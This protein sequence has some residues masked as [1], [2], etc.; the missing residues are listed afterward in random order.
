[1]IPWSQF[2]N[3]GQRTMRMRREFGKAASTRSS[4]DKATKLTSVRSYYKL[5][6][7]DVYRSRP[8]GTVQVEA[9]GNH[10]PCSFLSRHI[11]SPVVQPCC[12]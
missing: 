3:A 1:M 11:S 5:L 2:V 12:M 9:K 4:L 8:G 6:L 10:Q 7:G